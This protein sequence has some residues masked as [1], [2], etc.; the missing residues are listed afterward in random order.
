[1]AQLAAFAAADWVVGASGPDLAGLVFCATGTRVIEL[2]PQE[3]FVPFA[4][5]LAGKLRL[6]HAVLPG[7]TPERFA[8]L[9]AMLENFNV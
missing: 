9:A 5:M 7:G 6:L 2:A 8:A 3:G 4:W 1:M